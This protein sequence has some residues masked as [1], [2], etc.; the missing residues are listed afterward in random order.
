M[1]FRSLVVVCMTCCCTV[2]VAQQVAESEYTPALPYPA[3]AEGGGPRVAIDEAHFNYHT[4]DGRYEPFA[5][6][7]RRDGYLVSGFDEPFSTGSLQSTDILVV[8]NAL[9]ERNESDWG[10]PTP[11]AFTAEE[12][13]AVRSWVCNGGSLFLIADHMPFPGAASEL[14]AVFGVQYSNGYARPGHYER[15]VTDTFDASNGLWQS[16]I[17]F[18]RGPHESV[19]RVATFGGSAFIPPIN[20]TPVILFG[21]DSLSYETTKAPGISD[22]AAEVPVEGWCQGAV[23]RFGLGRVAVFGEA[24]MFSAQTSGRGKRPMGMNA[25]ARTS[26]G[27]VSSVTGMSTLRLPS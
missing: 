15:G 18:G 23:F 19:T 5:R 12:I 25:P 3:Y 26:T 17:T 21:A 4:V 7:L 22:D 20:A 6:L 10:L 16:P 24:A 27:I 2:A 14:A 9:N 8:V 11:S 13:T 1:L